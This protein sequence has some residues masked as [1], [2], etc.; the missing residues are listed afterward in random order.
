MPGGSGENEDEDDEEDERDAIP[1]AI[2]RQQPATEFERIDLGTSD[3]DGYEGED[4]DDPDV[5][6]D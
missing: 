3:V 4:G 5:D 2:Q 1:T 6:P